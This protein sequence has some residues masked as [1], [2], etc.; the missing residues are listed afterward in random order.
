VAVIDESIREAFL[1]LDALDRRTL[2]SL[3]APLTCAQFHA[4]AALEQHPGQTLSALAAR[5]LCAKA[6]ASGLVDRLSAMRLV[7]KEPDPH[8]GRCIRLSLTSAGTELL[9]TA[10]R[11]RHDAL[12][13]ELTAL[14]S[15]HDLP[16]GELAAMMRRM[17]E[18]LRATSSATALPARAARLPAKEGAAHARPARR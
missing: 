4:L 15:P 8:D 9:A 13:A 10:R 18:H 12:T 1:L 11:A 3:G 2:G 5:L 7:K 6:N 14:R 17:V 16:L